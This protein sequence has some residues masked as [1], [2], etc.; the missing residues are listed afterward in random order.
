MEAINSSAASMN[1][2]YTTTGCIIPADSNL[3]TRLRNSN[4]EKKYVKPKT[5]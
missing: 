1:L 5:R 2:F 4:E 3:H